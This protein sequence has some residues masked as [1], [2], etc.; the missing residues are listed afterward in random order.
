MRPE[1]RF[2]KDFVPYLE[3]GGC[4][5]IPIETGA[6]QTG[7]PDLYVSMKG[8]QYAVNIVAA[9]AKHLWIELKVVTP[10]QKKDP[11]RPAQVKRQREMRKNGIRVITVADVRDSRDNNCGYR[12]LHE[13]GQQ[14]EYIEISTLANYIL[15]ILE[16]S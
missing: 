4:Y 11:R 15:G 8:I 1:R 10:F 9:D 7:V 3:A 16:N 2:S 6:T 5:V 14:A 12:V 13:G